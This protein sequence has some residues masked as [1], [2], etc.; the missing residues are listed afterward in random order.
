MRQL[1]HRLASW[2]FQLE[3]EIL[4][5]FLAVGI[6]VLGGFGAISFYNG[7]TIQKNGLESMARQMISVINEEITFL[8]EYATEEEICEKYREN[9]PDYVRITDAR[10]QVVAEPGRPAEREKVVLTDSENSLSWRLE[11]IVDQKAFME[12]ILENQTYV[13]IGTIAALIIIIQASI[14]ISYNVALPIRNMSRT[15]QEINENRGSYRSYRFETVSRRD[16]IGQLAKTFELLLKNMDNY[17]K[18]EYTSRMS[19]TLAH[20]IKNPLAGIRSGIQVLK[21]RTVKEGDQMLCSTMIREI[22]RV[23][24]L[25]TNLCTLSVKRDSFRE[26]VILK[27]VLKELELFYA[28]GLKQQGITFSVSVKGEPSAF[29]NQDE[30]KQILHNLIGNSVK[31]IGKRGDGAIYLEAFME[32]MGQER[33]V[34]M[35][36]TDNGCGMTEEE[37]EKAMEPFYTKS[38]NGIGLGLAIV[39]KLTEQNG[40]SLQMESIPGVGTRTQLEFKEPKEGKHEPN[41]HSG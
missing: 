18:M 38:I 10:G 19:A 39:R 1:K 22:D 27:P 36:L 3:N 16:E 8:S 23:A 40:G 32:E 14:F 9:P 4:L 25:I 21:G 33:F 2:L 34:K 41:S 29:L 7:Y 17:T 31:A 26:Q 13:V 28:K 11:F 20:E 30:L 6:I 35:V 24:A 15:C 37:L 5:P 12:E